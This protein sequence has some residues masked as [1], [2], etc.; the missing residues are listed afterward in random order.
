MAHPTPY[1][2]ITLEDF[3][4]PRHEWTS[5]NDPVMGGQSVGHFSLDERNG[6][7]HFVGHVVDVPFLHAPGF[8]KIE[9]TATSSSSSE[10]DHGDWPD[11]SHCQGLQVLARSKSDYQGYKVSFGHDR[12]PHNDAFRYIY[13]YKANL[14]VPSSSSGD[15]SSAASSSSMMTTIQV[16]F[17]QFT[18]DWDPATGNAVVTCRDDPNYCPSANVKQNLSSIAIWAEGVAGPVDLE[19][20]KI[21]AYGCAVKTTADDDEDDEIVIEDFSQPL[22]VWTTMN[23][24]VM[25]GKST[26][27]VNI[28]DGM[29][30][31]RGTCAMVPF[32][33][34]PGFITLVTGGG[35]SSRKRAVFP[36][37]SHCAAFQVTLRTNVD[38]TGYYLSFGTVRVPGGGHA[39]GY[40]VP[41]DQ[42]T[43]GGDEFDTVILPFSS[44]SSKWDEATGKIQIKCIDDAQYCPTAESLMNLETMSFWGEGVV[45]DV[46][47]DIQSIRAVGC[48]SSSSS[49]SAS[50][51]VPPGK[52]HHKVGGN[53]SM[54]PLILLLGLVLAVVALLFRRHNRRRSMYG[55]YEELS[56]HVEAV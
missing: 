38:Y 29:A 51:K 26:S 6:L 12:P 3:S 15:E 54:Y 36:D 27:S 8:I 39:S 7:G 21:Q 34:A 24:P 23:D 42:L 50:L 25:G 9:S 22:N 4:N 14:P 30:S 53:R 35:W 46:S 56:G 28:H 20:E 10:N 41:L 13:G 40:K 11:I 19:L 49:T 31:F 37:I 44:F 43:K 55:R 18:D 33:H 47:L 2:V 32:L 1:E 5:M 52:Y 45:G 16:P 17:D 48:A